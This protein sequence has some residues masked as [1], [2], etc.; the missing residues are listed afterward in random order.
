MITYIYHHIYIYTVSWYRDKRP[1]RSD[2][3]VRVAFVSP[4]CLHLL[5]QALFAVTYWLYK[6]FLGDGL[7]IAEWSTVL[8]CHPSGRGGEK[9]R[10]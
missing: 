9:V 3:K 5:Y 2:L 7:D 1:P 4:S 6:A 10:R 8:A